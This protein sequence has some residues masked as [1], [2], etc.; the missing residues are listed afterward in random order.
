MDDKESK[1]TYWVSSFIDRDTAVNV[2]S[3]RTE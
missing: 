1:G 3:F 2:D